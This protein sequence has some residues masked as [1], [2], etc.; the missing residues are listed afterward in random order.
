MCLAAAAHCLGLPSPPNIVATAAVDSDG[1]LSE[2]G[3]L[4]EKLRALDQWALGVD[5][6]IVA[7]TQSSTARS[8]VQ[9]LGATWHIVG[10]RT[11]AEA[12]ATCFPNLWRDLESRWRDETTSA[13]VAS[14]LL[15]LA[16]D[17]SNHVLSWRG[18]GEAA[19]RLTASLP[20]DSRARKDARFA[21]LIA[22]R[23][24]GV[25][26]LL[27]LDEE[28]FAGM[29]RPLRLR[30]LAHVVQSHA[31]WAEDFVPE[32]ERAVEKLLP[33]DPADDSPDDLRVLGALGRWRAAFFRYEPAKEAL[34]RAVRGWFELD[35]VP[36]ASHALSE[37]LRVT[38]V[39]HA[40]EAFGRCVHDYA[41]PF[42][43][44]PR[45]AAVSRG[46]VLYALGRGRALLGDFSD[47]RRR[48]SDEACEWALVP[49][50]L[51]ALR[52]RWLIRAAR[53]A[54]DSTAAELAARELSALVERAPHLE[55][56][57]TLAELD[58]EL[59][60]R[61]D[62]H[63]VLQSLAKAT[64]VEYRRFEKAYG[65]DVAARLAREYRY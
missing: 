56:I 57:R 4:A 26:A 39:T 3:G 7:E 58:A 14:D 34:E 12:V 13:R 5:T 43:S 20:A 40:Q 23:H 49:D 64:P 48:L 38:A 1:A 27:P 31:D 16:R 9:T 30:C 17:G 15:R 61:R 25:E 42:L 37:L 8:I 6:V 62:G 22:R 44:D 2:V 28:H 54:G 35:C 10:A 55:Y 65:D 51:R 41:E 52:Q 19:A 63:E 45:S 32:L 33:R 50:H 18:I 47:A 53:S 11:V 36:E 60:V 24:E 29:R 59:E 21:E 46:F